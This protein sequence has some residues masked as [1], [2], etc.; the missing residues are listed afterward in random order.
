MNTP[1]DRNDAP[2]SSRP[3][4]RGLDALRLEA[5]WQAQEH[6]RE[7]VPRKLALRR[8]TARGRRRLGG[9]EEREGREEKEEE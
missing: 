8:S 3:S 1:N 9:R 7:Q 5:E 6:A 4:W 2:P